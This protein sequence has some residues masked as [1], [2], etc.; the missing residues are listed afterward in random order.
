MCSDYEFS[1]SLNKLKKVSKASICDVRCYVV[2]TTTQWK[3]RNDTHWAQSL[4]AQAISFTL[5]HS[6]L[7]TQTPLKEPEP[8]VPGKWDFLASQTF[9][10]DTWAPC[11]GWRPQQEDWWAASRGKNEGGA[12]CGLSDSEVGPLLH[13]QSESACSHMAPHGAWWLSMSCHT[14]P[15]LLAFVKAAGGFRSPIYIWVVL[16]YLSKLVK[17]QMLK[18]SD[19]HDMV[20][21]SVLGCF[22]TCLL[23]LVRKT[24]K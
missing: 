15:S 9:A 16:F 19:L 12:G 11:A 6:Q 2:P 7:H 23:H 1:F 18:L 24:V 22:H 3:I 4:H 8:N 21:W 5:S 20:S 14:R 10:T 17:Q 13:H